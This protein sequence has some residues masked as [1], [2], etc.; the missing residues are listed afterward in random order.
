MSVKFELFCLRNPANNRILGNVPEKIGKKYSS[1]YLLWIFQIRHY[2]DPT[3]LLSWWFFSSEIWRNL[4][5]FV[6]VATFR[7]FFLWLSLF[8]RILVGHLLR[9]Q[10]ILCQTF[11]HRCPWDFCH[12]K[13]QPNDRWPAV[14]A[15]LFFVSSAIPPFSVMSLMTSKSGSSK[16]GIFPLGISRES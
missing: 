15:I 16:T 14:S 9:N 1:K 8:E 5:C 6:W 13:I 11:L 2:Q 10:L 12:R 7:H 3:Q 4:K